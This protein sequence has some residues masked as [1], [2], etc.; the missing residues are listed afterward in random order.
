MD[1]FTTRRHVILRASDDSVTF[2][3]ALLRTIRRHTAKDLRVLTVSVKGTN[4]FAFIVAPKMNEVTEDV[5]L[6]TIQ[7]NAATK[8]Y[9]YHCFNPSVNMMFYEWG[10]N[11]D[12]VVKCRVSRKRVRGQWCYIIHGDSW[13]AL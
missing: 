13:E 6:P 8:E 9:G 7:Y 3:A 5:K 1:L 4:D 2:S 11:V 12:A 10:L